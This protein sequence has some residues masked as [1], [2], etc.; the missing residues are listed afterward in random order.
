MKQELNFT[1]C[2]L[3][4][5]LGKKDPLTFQ[6]SNRV[7]EIAASFAKKLGLSVKERM[8]LVVGALLHDIGKIQIDHNILTKNDRL[9]DEEYNQIK[10]HP[11]YGFEM[12]KGYGM[13]EEIYQLAL[14]HHERWDGRGYPY[15][16]AGEDI[17]FLSRILSLADTLDAMTGERPYREPMSW[18]KAYGEIARNL[19]TQFDPV[20]TK[21]FLRWMES[22][23]SIKNIQH[24]F[25]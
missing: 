5:N 21:E 4:R 23:K 22:I 17:P 10:L 8:E 15:G 6:H 3:M 7:T 24:L 12:L 11:L 2:M 16:L 14:F 1:L 18:V 25:Q 9:T 19:G 20:L 13:N